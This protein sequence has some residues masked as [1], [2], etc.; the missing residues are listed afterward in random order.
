[1][2][3]AVPVSS[4]DPFTDDFLAEPYPFHAQL[5]EAGPVVWLER[6]GL[7]ACARHA[8]VQASLSD[9]ETF[10]SAAG[11]GIDDFRRTKPWRPPS[12]ILEA[13]PPLHTRSRTVMNRALS[14]KAMAGLR[15][16][17][18]EAAESLADRLIARRRVDAVKDV[19]EAYPL[20]V[21]PKAIG[22]GPDG[23]ENLLPYGAMVFNAFGPRNAHFNAAMAAAAKVV[24]YINGQCAREKL[25]PNG[26]GA[27]IWA[28]VDTGEITAEEAPL[29]VRSLLSA[30]L[31]TTVVGIGNAL[32]AFAT[33]PD[34]WRR[35]RESGGSTRPAFDEVLRWESP[36]QTFFRTTTRPVDI[37]GI[38]IPRDAKI[39]LFLASANRDPRKWDDPDRFDVTRRAAGHVAFG[40][41]IHLCVGQMLARLEAEMIL[42]ALAARAARIDIAGEPRRKLG[43][44]LRQFA[45]LP[46]ELKPA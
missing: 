41:G 8:E 5:R 10:S 24:P 16:S 42:G 31:D 22:L 9:W 1:M 32:Y 27:T 6:Y 2:P 28:A 36:I 34:E 45:S 40:A 43:N 14:A 37:G 19:A 39:L 29:L 26:L 21:F 25:S 7:W 35:L 38:E 4:L 33:N 11:V 30:G 46:I 15:A 13:D 44:S 17:F 18:K 23:L 12:L 20:S 3:P